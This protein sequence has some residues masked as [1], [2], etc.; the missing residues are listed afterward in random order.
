MNL[1]S[2]KKRLIFV[3]LAIPLIVVF[4]LGQQ[5]ETAVPPVSAGTAEWPTVAAN[6]Q[7]T[8]W[9]PDEVGGQLRPEWYKPFEPFIPPHVQIIAANNTLYISTASGLYAI[10]STTGA[11]KWV[12][13]TEMPLGHSPTIYNGVAYV[14]GL[15][16]K[17][18][19]V[20]ATSG[21]GLWTFSADAGFET[22]PL[23]I[24]D[25]LY[26][27]S[28]DGKMYAITISGANTGQLAWSYQTGGPIL[29]S[30]AYNNGTIYFASNDSFAYALNAANGNLVW[31]SA[32]L[33]GAGFYSYWPVVYEDKVVFS[34]S[35]AYT[36]AISWPGSGQ[37]VKLE[38]LDLYTSQ[39]VPPGGII[40][41]VSTAVGD[42]TSGTPTINANRIYNYFDSKPW[43]RT[44]FVLNQTNG[45]ETTTAP[46][47]WTGTA[48]G[49]RYPPV[50]G[51]DGVL[52]Q[53]NNYI[54]DASIARGH[55]SG[56]QPDNPYITNISGDVAAVDEP[57]A[58]SGGGNI[59]YWNLCC[60]RQSG[61]VDITKPNS[62][63][64]NGGVDPTREWI[65]YG[66]NLLSW[67]PG[68]N[69]LYYTAQPD[70]YTKPYSNFGNVNGVYGFHGDVSPPIP[71]NGRV[72][73]QRSNTI[74]AFSAGSPGATGLPLAAKRT[75]P[76]ANINIPDQDDLIAELEAEVS[77]I[78][79]AGHLRPGFMSHGLFD[80]SANNTCGDNLIAYWSNPGDTLYTLLMAL[81]HLSPGLQQTVRTYLQNEYANFPPYQ[82][83]HTGWNNGAAREAY[84]MPPEIAA[85]LGGPETKNF[86]LLNSGGWNG[87]GAWGRNPFAW[88]AL[89]KYAEEFGGA[90]G[91]LSAS[92]AAFLEEFNN[93]PSDTFLLKMPLMHNAYIAGYIGYT[94]LQKL[95]GQ[96]PSSNVNNE[97]NRLLA[98]R[99]N[100]FTKDTAYRLVADGGPYC[101]TLNVASNF[102][103]LVPE[104]AEYLR[105]NALSGVNSALAEYETVAPYWFVTF[106]S[107]GY[108]E[109]AIVPLHDAHAIFMAKALI[110]EETGDELAKYL[111]VPGFPKGDLFYIQ[112]LTAAI[113][114]QVYGFSLKSTPVVANVDSGGSAN[115]AISVVG[116]GGF[117]APVNIQV[118]ESYS[119]LVASPTSSNINPP[120]SVVVTLDDNSSGSDAQWYVATVTGTGDGIVKSMQIRLLVNGSEVFLPIMA[121]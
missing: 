119:N 52:Y 72:Y 42:W 91:I 77:K 30:A 94:E 18:H 54:S 47:L 70:N 120:G 80:N 3:V 90:N 69:F 109:N 5:G 83:N 104:L 38:L 61:A 67:A 113:E 81:P 31:K 93:Q 89:W 25:K 28:R 29:Y 17:I 22:N 40:G 74:M 48:S 41:G 46:V 85:A 50:I 34:G 2:V 115:F 88:Y 76:A 116:T 55:I 58:A 12:Y 84:T 49:T 110:L 43:R 118:A 9:T 86:T 73:I 32:K 8:S 98:L 60:D 87:E 65:Y 112:K 59:I 27:G 95:A 97:L 23:V 121:R 26:A 10:D 75:P 36:T 35:N 99:A 45:A 96:T 82:Y 39:G 107:G 101:R 33:P 117:V 20:D 102:M 66:Y 4:L 11:E 111:D 114:N 21:V 13:P 15:D 71:Y 6:P 19:A 14:G 92:Q 68:Y 64:P 53:Q 100:N 63:F 56:W 1:V 79:E 51:V 7:R 37:L 57:H 44:V 103:Y 106:F 78:M 105:N 24:D 108:A 16:N 62:S